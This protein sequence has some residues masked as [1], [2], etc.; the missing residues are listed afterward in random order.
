MRAASVIDVWIVTAGRVYTGRSIRLSVAGLALIVAACGSAAS[1]SPS[2][3]ATPAPTPSATPT[4]TPT[5]TLAPTATPTLAPTPAPAP[6]ATPAPSATP[7]IDPTSDLK[8]G[9]GYTLVPLDPT[10]EATMKAAIEQSL[11]SMASLLE[12]GAKNVNRGTTKT[13]FVMVVAYPGLP[14]ASRTTFFQS[15][16]NGTVTTSGAKV[17]SRPTISGHAVI[18]AAAAASAFAAYQYKDG[19]VYAYAAT[20]KEALAIITAVIKA[21]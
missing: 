14:A 18:V 16:V 12:F 19:I 3:T 13:G 15:A 10:V 7:A 5:P 11:G 1:P 17:V 20:A 2:P 8:I 9:G 21:N 4:A 6:T